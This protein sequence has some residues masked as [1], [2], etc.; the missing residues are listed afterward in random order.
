MSEQSWIGQSVK[1]VEDYRLLTGRG[2]HIDDHPPVANIW[3]A[4]IVR[5]PHAHARILGYDLSGALAMDGVIGAIT[6]ADVLRH[7]KPFSVGV[8]CFLFRTVT[9]TIP[10]EPRGVGRSMRS[11]WHS[12]DS[13]TAAGR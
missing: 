6:G 3:H 13:E 8:T 5:S 2:A 7:S 10:P 1:R 12:S 11:R 9:G 4:A